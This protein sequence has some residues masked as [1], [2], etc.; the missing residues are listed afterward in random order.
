MSNLTKIAA[1]V[2]CAAGWAGAASAAPTPVQ[3]V[4]GWDLSQYRADDTLDSGA[5]PAD[6]LPANYSSHD[7]TAGAGAGSAAFG[8][9]FMDGSFGSTNVTE[10]GVSPEVVAHAHETEANREAPVDARG[11]NTFPWSAFDSF[12]VLASEGQVNQE[13]TGITA[14]AP[15]D[16][17]F[18]AD[19]GAAATGQWKL[20]LAGFA[21]DP[22]GPVTVPVEFAPSCGAYSSAGSLSLN[23][24][25]QTFSLNVGAAALTDD[26]VCVRLGLDPT[27]G[28]PVI[29]NVALPEA[30]LASMLAAGALLVAGLERRRRA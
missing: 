4:A 1:I 9:L 19:R 15:V 11:A 6:T 30:G 21:L 27:N 28:Q 25:E 26:D 23:G 13:R 3:L 8:T 24:T 18:R 16:V 2:V 14:R 5:G 12:R 17:V 10:A 29:D 20:S 22:T 7:A